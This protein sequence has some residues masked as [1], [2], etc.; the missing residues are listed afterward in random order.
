MNS[1]NRKYIIK[2]NL[3]KQ[4]GGSSLS[5]IH[6]TIFPPKIE[7]TIWV[8]KK[9]GNKV[10]RGIIK[11]Y[12][13]NKT[14]A[15]MEIKNLDKGENFNEVSLKEYDRFDNGNNHMLI[16]PT[17]LWNYEEIEYKLEISDSPKNIIET[18]SVKNN[19]KQSFINK[20]KQT[21]KNKKDPIKKQVELGFKKF[22]NNM[23][24]KEKDKVK[25]D[26]N[27]T[28]LELVQNVENSKYFNED[29]IDTYLV[30]KESEF[31][32][33][34]D[35][36]VNILLKKL[37]NFS[38]VDFDEIV[39]NETVAIN[40]LITKTEDISYVGKEL[41]KWIERSLKQDAFKD[42][43]I[44]IYN[45]YVYLS[46]KG[47]TTTDIITPELVPE[48]HFF[49]WQHGKS[50]DYQTLK[51]VVF[52]NEYQ[53]GLITN[54]NQK[55]E[56][57]KILSQENVIALQPKPKYQMWVV[58]RLLMIWYGDKEIEQEIR[59]I[60]ILIN[61]FRADDTQD[62]NKKYGI[63]PSIVIYPKYGY[64]SLRKVLS[65]IQYYFSMYLD[66]DKDT[67]EEL[68][69][70]TSEPTYFL[71]K[72][73]LIFHTNGSIDL[74]LYLKESANDQ[75]IQIDSFAEDMSRFKVYDR[76]Q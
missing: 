34:P 33:L 4:S 43:D 7:S 17:H 63:L 35:E 25:D 53:K 8:K 5:P 56:A 72:N 45:G 28:Q 52:Q 11:E 47:L 75:N 64:N 10:F 69:W 58:K 23:G 46:R 32:S 37:K 13:W 2:Y 15:V 9:E 22:S 29:K 48:L 62:Y 20:L 18:K 74:K 66:D 70:G 50:I 3:Y 71:K 6:N 67:V 14:A 59:K 39:V 30:D 61:Q 68:N 42:L 38:P 54:M 76:L 27:L 44:T 40:N 41:A 24:L 21:K 16:L 49:N 73:N 26:Q 51:Y 55:L 57:E 36:Y 31:K 1:S 65:K 19:K 12:I 60:K